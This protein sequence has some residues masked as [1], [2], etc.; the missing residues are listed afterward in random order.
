MT[1]TIFTIYLLTSFT[2][3]TILLH[4]TGLL[5][6]KQFALG[7]ATYAISFA[8]G[9]VWP[10]YVTLTLCVAPVSASYSFYAMWKLSK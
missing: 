6:S 7:V 2:V 10:L 1:F 4:R 9:W 5:S 3:A 8:C